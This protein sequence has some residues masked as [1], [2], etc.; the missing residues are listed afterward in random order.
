[1]QIDANDL[2]NHEG[3][4]LTVELRG[5]EDTVLALVCETDDEEIAVETAD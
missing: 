3:H 2:V 1:M 5:P 4:R